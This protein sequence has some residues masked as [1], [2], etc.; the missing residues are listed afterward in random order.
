MLKPRYRVIKDR[1]V[2]KNRI[3]GLTL[4]KDAQDPPRFYLCHRTR[5]D[6]V[7]IGDAALALGQLSRQAQRFKAPARPR[8]A[9]Y[10]RRFGRRPNARRGSAAAVAGGVGGRPAL[11][12]RPG[13]GSAG[14]ETSGLP[15]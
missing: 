4:V 6:L 9:K 14:G 8:A 5:R 1:I 15:A 11:T 7:A 2:A 3:A 13:L 10:P 12:A